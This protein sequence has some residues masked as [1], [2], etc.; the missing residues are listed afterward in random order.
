MSTSIPRSPAR[1]PHLGQVFQ[2]K[3][4]IRA[5]ATCVERCF[6]ELDLMHRWLNPALR[7]DP[8]GR[9]QTTVGS[10]SRFVIQLP[11]WQPSLRSTV[12]ERQPGLVVWQ[13]DGF[14]RGCD[15][16]EC[17]PHPNGTELLNRFEFQVPN[18]VVQWGFKTF[19]ASLTRQDM[20]AQLRRLKQVAERLEQSGHW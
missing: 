9:W 13:F 16:W 7:C 4:L 2:Q 6:T 17:I 19:A 18:P 3:I 8:V 15:R 12:I 20:Q 11:L 5:S 10:R 1:P 14:F